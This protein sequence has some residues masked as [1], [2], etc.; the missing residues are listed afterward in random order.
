MQNVTSGNRP[1]QKPPPKIGEK[2]PRI[3]RMHRY[4]PVLIIALV[5]AVGCLC[6]DRALSSDPQNLPR[7]IRVVM[8]NNYPP[9]VFLDADGNLRGILIDQWQ[10]WEQRT[11][12]KVSISGMDW[13]EALR[14]MGEG[15]FDVIDTIFFNERR[16]KIYDFSKPYAKLD[17]SIFFHKSISGIS[18]ADSLYG[19]P[20]A[21]KT[22][23]NCIDYLKGK[24]IRLFQEYPSYEAIIRAAK[25]Q[26]VMVAVID[27][28][29]AL[30]FL[31][32]MGILD[33]F[34]YSAPLYT[35]E[36]HRAVRKGNT[37]ILKLVEEGFAQISESDYQAIHRKWFGTETSVLH[38][39]LR[40]IAMGLGALILIVLLLIIWNRTLRKRVR[41]RTLSLEEQVALNVRKTAALQE[42]EEKYRELVENANSIILRMDKEGQVAFFNE[43]AQRF[44][45]FPEEDI[46]GRNVVGTIVPEKETTGRDLAA[47]IADIGRNPEAYVNNENENMRSNGE[48]VWI[49]WTNKP[50]LTPDGN[51][52]EILCVGNDITER[53]RIEEELYIK[54]RAI[55]SSIDAVAISDLNGKFAYVNDAFS[56]MWGYTPQEL[57]G[58]NVTDLA[59]SRD[60]IIRIVNDIKEKGFG[61]GESIAKRSDGSPFVI[62]YSA[63]LVT[64]S[65]GEPLAMLSTF[66]DITEHKRAEEALRESEER[67]NTILSNVGAYIFLKDT[68]YR[69]TYAN[70]KVCDLFG[71]KVDEIVGKG[72]AS[73]FSLASVEE[74]MK[75]DRRVIEQGET[76]IR[77][78]TDLTSS[79]KVPRSYWVVKLPLKDSSGKIYGLCG[80][81]TDITERK[82]AEKKLKQQT[83]AME[84]SMDGMAILNEDQKYV[85]LNKAHAKIYGYD[86]AE[87]LVGQSWRILY[88]EDELQRFDRS[89][90][91]E[92]SRKGQWQGEARGRRKDGSAFPQEISLTA[93]DKGQLICVVRDST[94]R[95]RVEEA[96][97]R[98]ENRLSS[99]NEFLPDATFAIDLEGKII[100][101]NRAIE[102]M[103]GFS[104]ETMLGKGDYEYAIPFYGERRPILVNFL[105]LWNDDIA[106][107]YSFI[108]K[109]GDTLYTETDV[110]RVRGQNRILW[111]KA[112]PLRN[113]RGDVIGAIESIRDITDRKRLESQL[114]QAQKMEAIGT[115]AGGIAHDFNNILM[116]IQGYASLIM[117]ELD[118]HNPH[119]ERLK[120]IEEQ[121]QSATDL[122]RQLLG[123]A[124]GGR[125]EMRPVNMN[126][127][128]RRTSSM[129]GRTKKELTIHGRY[130]NDLWTAE[131]DQGQIEQV[132]LNLYVNAWHAMSTGGELYLETRNVALDEKYATLHAVSPG[133]Y[134]KISVT[135]TGMGMDKKTMERIFDPFFTTKEMGRGTGL[136]LA[137]VYGIMKG[138]KGFVNVYSEPGHGT[139]FTLYL[140]ASDKE[141]PDQKTIPQEI[142]RGSE[143]IL[144]VD[145]EPN[146]LTVS[147]EILE[148][149]G[150]TVH[151]MG[152]GQEAIAFYREMTND[153]ALVIL[154][155]IMPG[156]SGSETFDRIRE[157]N[158]S[159]RV[160]LS[161]G[162]SLNGQAQQIM[163]KGC[164]GF[165]Q[166]PFNITY[167]ARKIRDVLDT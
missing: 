139:S 127:I 104:A 157:L 65:S 128:I 5:V 34:R 115:L 77:E 2:N 125:Y 165:I 99:I 54:D 129:F 38:L 30:Y 92:F 43:F 23:D 101:W 152:S 51:I 8:D 90:M 4:I 158:P 160:I 113:E 148:S 22:G 83:D 17:V 94:E 53:K 151:A 74:I 149:L 40:P 88:D 79:D 147:K 72:D 21:V 42:S 154:D 50:I 162:Y 66:V 36:F 141:V 69:Y 93:L 76:V 61:A 1:E 89:I 120:R 130:A 119:Y 166:K 117:L 109:D 46:I 132:F 144:L 133:N 10:L 107:K 39:Y 163:D 44:F 29:P 85:Y 114:L 47:M 7:T 82:E 150:Y 95:K 16:A 159:A 60:E 91:P 9:Y 75:S 81:S 26:K 12:V 116:G 14:R 13:G 18:D 15:E 161:S 98:S 49:A 124:R 156:L 67:Q 33:Q 164:Y 52:R 136:G 56:R 37:T 103:T 58:I 123:F 27:N 100:S 140:P 96:L 57:P 87:E 135:D 121:V 108:Q 55:A 59:L 32:K 35:G 20:V 122:T 62:Q 167:I 6:A 80:I 118:P 25:E 146:V 106:E 63:S 19:F 68:Q 3:R 138:H 111:G 142:P 48:R 102:E 134:V 131:V 78:E 153:I 31:Y 41:E 70:S 45:G 143:T 64:G 137:M 28:P 97:K 112:S 155:M 11:G 84:A 73:F 71:F 105:F 24:G 86:T 145:D 110:P 126:E